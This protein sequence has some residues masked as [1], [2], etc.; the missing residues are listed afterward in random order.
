MLIS[1]FKCKCQSV[2]KNFRNVI[3][4]TFGTNNAEFSFNYTKSRFLATSK[5]KG[6]STSGTEG[7]KMGYTQTTIICAYA[8]NE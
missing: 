1:L 5:I 2:W 6:N 3:N 8:K 4:E 7:G